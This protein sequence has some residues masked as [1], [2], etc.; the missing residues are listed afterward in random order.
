MLEAARSSSFDALFYRYNSLYLLRRHFR[1]IGLSGDLQPA[2]AGDR[3]VLYIMNHS[4]WWDG[5]LAYHAAKVLTRRRQYFM[6]EEAQLR[7][8]QFFRRLGAYSINRSEPADV[9]ASLRY[10]AGLLGEGGSV[11]MYPEGELLPLEHRPLELKEG[12]AVVLR[13]CPDAAVV[14]VTLYHGLFFHPKPE[15]TLVAGPPQIHPWKAMDRHSIT[16]LLASCL[17]E[18]LDGHRRLILE[19]QG[20]MPA[21]FEPLM[22]TGGSVHERYDAWR[23]GGR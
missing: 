10:T 19:H 15:A 16:A 4:S 2:S 6:M 12:A 8:F 7:K 9:R 18:Q 13:L 23:R 20:H 17:R 14:P 1:A 11:W 5:L 21:G 22:K 3:P